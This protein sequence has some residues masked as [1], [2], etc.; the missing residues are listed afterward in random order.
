MTKSMDASPLI[1]IRGEYGLQSIR[2]NKR[3]NIRQ[4]ALAS[5]D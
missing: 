5:L 4:N 1:A 2:L 3:Y